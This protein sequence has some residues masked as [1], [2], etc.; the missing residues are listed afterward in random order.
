MALPFLSVVPAAV[1][2][3]LSA[4]MICRMSASAVSVCWAVLTVGSVTLLN[5]GSIGQSLSF[6]PSLI[7][8]S[9]TLIPLR[10]NG[11]LSFPIFT[12]S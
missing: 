11:L 3:I 8:N 10:W 12:V 5:A 7:R 6:G 2:W 1:G 4:S 9:S